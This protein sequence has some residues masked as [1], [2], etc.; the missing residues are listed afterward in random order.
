MDS[1][2]AYH[3][4]TTCA[5]CCTS[6][7]AIV[8][9]AQ[10]MQSKLISINYSWNVHITCAS[11]TIWVDNY[12]VSTSIVIPVFLPKLQALQISAFILEDPVPV[13]SSSAQK[14]GLF[15]LLSTRNE[16]K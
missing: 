7:V 1:D 16:L 3:N 14:A 15:R 10:K 4:T 11:E 9:I 12:T 2:F 8:L 5:F 13:Y 6:M